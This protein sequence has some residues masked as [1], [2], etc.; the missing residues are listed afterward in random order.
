MAYARAAA[1]GQEELRRAPGAA[2]LVTLASVPGWT[3]W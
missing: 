1:V 3:A 2:Y